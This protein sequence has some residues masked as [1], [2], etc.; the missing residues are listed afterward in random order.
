MLSVHGLAPGLHYG[1]QGYLGRLEFNTVKTNIHNWNEARRDPNGEILI[2]RPDAN[3]ARMRRSAAF[4]SM[5]EVPEEIFLESVHLAVRRNA[6]YV[7]PHEVEGSLYIRPFQFGSSAQIGLEPPDEFLFCVFVQPHIGFHGRGSIK[8]LVLDDFDRAA[9]RGSGA[10]KVGG[11]YAP[12]I[13]WTAEA[14]KKGY[15]VLLHVDSQTQTEIDEF[16]TSGFIGIQEG[17]RETVVV[18]ANSKAAIES[19]TADSAA[20]IAVELGWRVEKRT[21]KLAELPTFTEVLAAGTASGLAPV[22]CIHRKSTN[23]TF[24]FLPG[25]PAYEKLWGRL[26][27]IQNGMAVDNFG[28]CHKL[29]E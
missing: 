27:S 9:T 6:E 20:K 15:N 26:K 28:W 14:R 7:C 11:N 29:L 18:I 25:G 1:A 5:P 24:H 16:S 4:V 13:R 23:E 22:S 12:V 17:D 8:A 19:I 2:F 3:A 10:V 21:V